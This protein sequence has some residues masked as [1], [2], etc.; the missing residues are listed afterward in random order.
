[1]NPYQTF[2]K[3]TLSI[4]GSKDDDK[5]KLLKIQVAADFVKTMEETPPEPRYQRLQQP[6]PRQTV[7][8]PSMTP[9]PRRTPQ[10][11]PQDPLQDMSIVGP[12]VTEGVKATKPKG[13]R[14]GGII[15]PA[16]V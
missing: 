3:Q 1:M 15:T 6:L 14:M 13:G 9:K 11:A 4:L 16:E 8:E 7:D 2:H 5:T 12:G 10:N